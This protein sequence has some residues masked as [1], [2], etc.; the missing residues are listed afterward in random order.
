MRHPRPTRRAAVQ[1][2]IAG[3][4]LLAAPRLRA[5]TPTKLSLGRVPVNAV[6]SNYVGPVDFFREEGLTLAP[7]RVDNPGQLFQAMAAGD[8]PVGEIGVGPSIIAL[9]RGLPF[10]APFLGSCSAPDHPFERIMV[11]RDSPIKTLDDL[12]GKKL[13][14]QGP[15]SVPDLLLGALP[16]KSKITKADIRLVQLPPP[17]QP[18][19]LGRG[20]VDA[21]FSTPPVDTVAE[22]KYGART[23]AD[24]TELVPYS[25]LGGIVIRRDFADSH[26]ETVAKLLR[27]CIRFCRWID[28]NPQPARDISGRNLGLP[29]D[30]AAHARLPLFT[31]NGL[32]VMPNAWHVYHMLL[33]AKTIDPH[34]DPAKLFHDAIVA[35]VE[36]FTL[37]AAD[38]LGRQSDPMSLKMLTADYPMLPKPDASYYADWERHLLK[39]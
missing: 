23:L 26:P 24:A 31:R 4:G 3:A 2:L 12:K 20:L 32:P 7:T 38:A 10:I 30:I 25:G 29:P 11:L 5:Q 27:A 15:G 16:R 33:A 13:G 34:S 14:Y 19:A 8:L 22:I 9:C 35:P 6:V 37:P 1:T 21:I 17:A 28:D 39:S 36:R 18:D